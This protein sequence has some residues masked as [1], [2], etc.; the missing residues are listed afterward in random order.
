[1][2]HGV[3]PGFA[4]PEAGILMVCPACSFLASPILLSCSISSTETPYCLEIWVKVSPFATVCILVLGLSAGAG[5]STPA[6]V[7]AGFAVAGFAAAAGVGVLAG[8]ALATAGADFCLSISV[9]ACNSCVKWSIFSPCALISAFK[10][11]SATVWAFKTKVSVFADSAA[12]S[13]STL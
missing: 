13:A 3:G 9:K 10:A 2:G 4:E 11:S 7:A 12:P 6:T 1:M 8:S 5:L